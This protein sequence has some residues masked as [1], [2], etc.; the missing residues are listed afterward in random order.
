MLPFMLNVAS[1]LARKIEATFAMVTASAARVSSRTAEKAARIHLDV[2]RKALDRARVQLERTARRQGGRRQEAPRRSTVRL[3]RE[4]RSGRT[5]LSFRRRV[6]H[7]TGGAVDF[8]TLERDT[9][10]GRVRIAAGPMSDLKDMRN[11]V[12]RSLRREAPRRQAAQEVRRPREVAR[13]RGRGPAREQAPRREVPSPGRGGDARPREERRVDAAPRKEWFSV[14]YVEGV[15]GNG[16]AR[17]RVVK[18]FDAAA[19]AEAARKHDRRLIVHRHEG[20]R[21]LCRGDVVNIDPGRVPGAAA[22]MKEA[23][24]RSQENGRARDKSLSQRQGGQAQLADGR[25]A[26]AGRE[27]KRQ[28]SLGR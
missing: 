7:A 13:G 21:P 3:L 8:W 23:R 19:K 4:V 15:N 25:A 14:V 18:S 17:T 2:A 22:A 16:T 20:R 9:P 26:D 10:R 5:S 11:V 1:G 6:D 28:Q 27:Q 12:A 24:R